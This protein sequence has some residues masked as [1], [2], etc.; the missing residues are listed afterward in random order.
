[1]GPAERVEAQGLESAAWTAQEFVSP[2]ATVECT[3][4]YQLFEGR[5]DA[6]TATVMKTDQWFFRDAHI[7][8]AMG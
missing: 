2:V 8:T 7:G 1:M 4:L 6:W 5:H 3:H